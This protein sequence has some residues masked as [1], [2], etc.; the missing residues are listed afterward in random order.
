M[1]ARLAHLLIRLY[2]R[3]WRDR[4]GEEFA[5]LLHEEQRS[6]PGALLNVMGAAVHEHLFPTTVP[7][8]ATAGASVLA[9]ARRPSAL[10]PLIMSVLALLLLL[11]FLWLAS[12][13]V[14]PLHTDDGDEGLA[15]RLWQLL[16]LGQVP[17]I[18]WFAV[19]WIRRRPLQAVLILA[20]QLLLAL[21][22]IVPILVLES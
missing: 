1:N 6:T 18:A 7:A 4:Y 16:M 13:G 20:V 8:G 14:I 5:Q 2:P 22:S 17:L 21:A 10:L 12:R 15:A 19:R 3:A 11:G 9:L